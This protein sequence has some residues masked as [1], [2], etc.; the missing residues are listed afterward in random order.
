[1]VNM[2][3][4]RLL[5]AI[6]FTASFV[7]AARS[8]PAIDCNRN[9]VDDL[10]DI[11]R[12]TASDCNGNGIPDECE[13]ASG[14]IVFE[15]PMG[16]PELLEGNGSWVAEDFDG[17]G[18]VDIAANSIRYVS[19]DDVFDKPIENGL[20]LVRNE[21]G[22]RFADPVRTSVIGD[23]LDPTDGIYWRLHAA[24]LD[25]DG[26]LDLLRTGDETG[27][28]PVLLNDGIGNF[29]VTV[30]DVFPLG[31]ESV[32]LGDIDGD[33][34]IDLAAGINSNRA[35][36]EVTLPG[37][38]SIVRNRGDGVLEPAENHPVFDDGGFG[39]WSLRAADLES[40]GDLDF[41][42][43]HSGFLD[44][45]GTQ[46]AVLRNLGGGN[47]ERT[48]HEVG[49]RPRAAVVADIDGDMDLDIL[50]PRWEA[51]DLAVLRNRGGGAFEAAPPIA[52]PYKVRDSLQAADLDGDGDVDLAIGWGAEEPVHVDSGKVS[53][54]MNAG[55]GVF[56]PA[57]THQLAKPTYGPLL[58][59]LNGDG[60]LDALV[61]KIVFQNRGGG[62]F[63][64]VTTVPGG[65]VARDMDGDGYRDLLGYPPDFASLA[66]IR[67]AT[68]GGLAAGCDPFLRGD[69][70]SDGAVSISD[71]LMLRRYMFGP[72]IV[73]NC[74]DAA[75][76]SDDE[77]ISICDDFLL[78]HALFQ[79]SDW[80]LSL[81]PP[82]IQP[83]H[84]PTPNFVA[85][86]W[87]FCESQDQGTRLGC[88][89]YRP[90]PAEK[91]GDLVIIGD[92]EATPG[93]D[94]LIPIYV[95][96]SVPVEAVQLVLRYDPAIE[97]TGDQ[98]YGLDG[99]QK[100]VRRG[101]W[102]EGL[103]GK[104]PE[105]SLLT[106]HSGAGIVTIAIV[107]SFFQ[108]GFDIPPGTDLPIAWI[109][110]RISPDVPPGTV[111]RLSP[112]TDA[113][114]AGPFHLRNEI[115]FQG[116][117]RL[118]SFIPNVEEGR[119]SIIPDQAFFFKRGDSDSS[120]TVDITDPIRTLGVLFLGQGFFLCEDAADANDDGAVDIADPILTLSFLFQGGARISEPYPMPGPDLTE[121]ALGCFSIGRH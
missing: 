23:P 109:P 51:T 86:D 34:D 7:L 81:P 112:V 18:R 113:G 70:N 10:Q 80:S 90:E 116:G 114:G 44:R 30:H 120:G 69:V 54:L 68:G 20:L 62:T 8:A 88:F 6:A 98:A 121:D 50:V 2:L 107:G 89:S 56:G 22:G 79:S 16:I 95:S 105:V 115:T 100:L 46:V 21:G 59:D 93:S 77:N 74:L 82:S 35:W 47:F 26:D 33:G 92:I 53:F 40:D 75:D 94:V 13:T 9:G 91:S 65:G 39:I 19:D 28:V 104:H 102:Y 58:V 67:N 41:V 87:G 106:V 29:E 71:M 64:P 103:E 57:V 4:K 84:D 48:I 117:S 101:T 83:G 99:V 78:L 36:I 96:A 111:L 5:S 52:M 11:A 76:V 24:D 73:L 49:E 15:T 32:V 42:A 27:E 61:G 63:D 12:G 45:S 25:G 3:S 17:D 85:R 108:Q 43:T 37:M 14:D 66:L 60:L 1:M 55:G 118:V 119:A 38:L 31:A 97:F 72:G 110:A